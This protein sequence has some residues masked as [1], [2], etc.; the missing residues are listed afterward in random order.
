MIGEVALDHGIHL[1]VGLIE[2]DGGTTLLYDSD[3]WA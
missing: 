3:L 1:V 2:R